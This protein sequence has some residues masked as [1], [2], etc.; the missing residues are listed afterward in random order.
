MIQA[1][2]YNYAYP[3]VSVACGEPQYADERPASL[4]NPVLLVEVVSD[5]TAEMDRRTKLEAYTQIES[6]QA[7]WIVEQDEPL[8]THYERR[9]DTWTVHFTRGLEAT[10]HSAAFDL[11]VPMA[12]LYD[13][14]PLEPEAEEPTGDSEV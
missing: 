3:D 8:I 12:D 13:Q 14:V 5:S 7:Y 6:L 4:L 11:A 1:K 2:W 10:L 9:G